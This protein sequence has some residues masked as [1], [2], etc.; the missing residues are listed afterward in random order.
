MAPAVARRRGGVGRQQP[1]PLPACSQREVG[2]RTNGNRFAVAVYT[3]RRESREAGRQRACARQSAHH[4]VARPRNLR[5]RATQP[6]TRCRRAAG[7]DPERAH[8][9]CTATLSARQT[10]S[11]QEEES[12]GERDRREGAG[13]ER[14]AGEQ[15]RERGEGGKEVRR[16][17]GGGQEGRGGGREAQATGRGER[18]CMQRTWSGSGAAVS[19]VI[20]SPRRKPS[21]DLAQQPKAHESM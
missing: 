8:T 19:V 15:R 2:G 12:G 18:L 13:G 16:E 17:E 6:P 11:R 5:E 4:G 14:R 1:P 7:T 20:V 9:H 21:S 3:V 10:G